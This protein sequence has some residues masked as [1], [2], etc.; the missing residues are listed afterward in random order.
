MKPFNRGVGFLSLLLAL[1][2]FFV[3]VGV[4]VRITLKPAIQS[5]NPDYQTP[6]QAKKLLP[7]TSIVNP[8]PNP[9]PKNPDPELNLYRSGG[10]SNGE[11]VLVKK[12]SLYETPPV[13]WKDYLFYKADGSQNVV[14]LNLKTQQEKPVAG[15]TKLASQFKNG[16]DV[17]SLVNRV[18]LNDLTVIDDTLYVSYG[19]YLV[20]A[21]TF[22]VDLNKWS[23]PVKLTDSRNGYIEKHGNTYWLVGGEG[24]A[25]WSQGSYSLLDTKA[26]KILGTL[27]VDSGCDS[28]FSVIGFDSKRERILMATY[29]VKGD[30]LFGDFIY[31]SFVSVPY[32]NLKTKKVLISESEFPGGNGSFL[33]KE[34]GDLLMYKNDTALYRVDLKRDKLVKGPEIKESLKAAK[35]SS[36]VSGGVCLYEGWTTQTQQEKFILVDPDSFEVKSMDSQECRSETS[37]FTDNYV[38]RKKREATTLFK[39]FNLPKE[40]SFE[41]N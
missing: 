26:R 11:R 31:T 14:A 27:D 38:A 29:T 16:A 21:A 35:L 39:G 6:Q 19:G 13:R 30:E 4:L 1:L 41:I 3:L 33:Y 18:N 15:L 36:F 34:D 17:E 9:A 37:A 22:W 5:S 25:C 20:T 40:Y 7:S 23:V 10:Q 24:D 2:V 28:G 32:S 8:T 12:F